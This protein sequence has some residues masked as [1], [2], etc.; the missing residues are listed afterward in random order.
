MAWRGS[1]VRIPSAPQGA[2][3]RTT[4][5]GPSSSVR[6]G[7]DEP[8][9]GQAGQTPLLPRRCESSRWVSTMPTASMSAYIVVGPTNTNPLRLSALD[10]ASDSGDVVG[11]SAY[12]RGRGVSAGR[13]DQTK[14][15]RPPSDRKSVV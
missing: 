15:S 8:P 6:D 5:S 13:N 2:K 11:T 4:S 7:R 12:V 1:G 9:A 3:G 10:R 14:V